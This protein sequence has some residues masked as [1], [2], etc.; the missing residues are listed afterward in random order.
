MFKKGQILTVISLGGG[1]Q[2][3]GIK[4]G[5]RVKVLRVKAARYSDD[6]YVVFSYGLGFR[7]QWE[8]Y[9]KRLRL[10]NPIKRPKIPETV[11]VRGVIK[12]V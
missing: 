10:V 2:V 12:H 11:C 9:A 7:R 8:C 1:L 3:R 6:S 4:L 5:D